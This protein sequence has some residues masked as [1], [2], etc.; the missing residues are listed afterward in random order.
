MVSTTPIQTHLTVRGCV[1]TSC[2]DMVAWY[3]SGA[4]LGGLL[5][6]DESTKL[7]LARALIAVRDLTYEELRDRYTLEAGQVWTAGGMRI[8]IRDHYPALFRSMC[9]NANVHTLGNDA[10][11]EGGSFTGG[12]ALLRGTAGTGNSTFMFVMFIEFLKMLRAPSTEE[13][14]KVD[15]VVVFNPAV[16]SIR[17]RWDGVYGGNSMVLR[18]GNAQMDPHRRVHLFDA[19]RDEPV[20]ELPGNQGEGYFLA[21]SSADPN[22]Y[23]GWESKQM[24]LKKQYSVLWSAEELLHL[25]ALKSNTVRI[26]RQQLY[27]RYAVVGGVPRLILYQ[28]ASQLLE[29]VQGRVKYITLDMV[30]TVMRNDVW[31]REALLHDTDSF[32]MFAMDV[33]AEGD[34]DDVRVCHQ[35]P[36]VNCGIGTRYS[37]LDLYT[38]AGEV[39]HA[40]SQSRVFAQATAASVSKME[41]ELSDAI[42]L[43]RAHGGD[44]F[45]DI[46][47]LKLS[48]DGFDGEIS[49]LPPGNTR[50]VHATT[51]HLP[52]CS[53]RSFVNAE[54]LAHLVETDV[55]NHDIHMYIPV[56]PNNPL[57]NAWCICTIGDKRMVVGLQVAVAKLKHP[58]AGESVAKEQFDAIHGALAK[59]PVNVHK[60]AWVVLVVPEANCSKTAHQYANVGPGEPQRN[61]GHIWPHTQAK[62]SMQQGKPPA[63][64]AAMRGML[65]RSAPVELSADVTV[66]DLCTLY[67]VGRRRAAQLLSVLRDNARNESKTVEGFLW[68]PLKTRTRSWREF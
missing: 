46:A 24:R 26:S 16:T 38:L 37:A 56:A 27:D 39:P 8:M 68:I 52:P 7:T 65:T 41:T 58:S 11:W 9:K 32:A 33:K 48:R 20:R 35:A 29:T 40:N 6:P 3:H 2:T 25:I 22:H 42:E 60:A 44:S 61:A 67:H 50:A 64:E 14:V 54:H 28:D 66:G 12:H 10:V 49:V 53:V 18:H 34:F 51:M 5:G 15:G 13:V 57:V 19:G 62:L 63:N 30:R 43:G 45:E 47:V 36:L 21:T 23:R 17:I 55:K 4:L 1:V 31:G 59:C